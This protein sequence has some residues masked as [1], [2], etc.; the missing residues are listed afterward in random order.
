[1]VDYVADLAAKAE[2]RVGRG[3]YDNVQTGKRFSKGLVETI[4]KLESTPVPSLRTLT[5]FREIWRRWQT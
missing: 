2:A 1:M 3:Y 4:Q 5:T